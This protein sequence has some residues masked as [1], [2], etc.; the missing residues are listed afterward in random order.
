MYI[1]PKICNKKKNK[2]KCK[3]FF[4]YIVETRVIDQHNMATTPS[5]SFQPHVTAPWPGQMQEA[6]AQYLHI[7]EFDKMWRTKKS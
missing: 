4:A 2:K 6:D 5:A 7:S 1:P 3:N